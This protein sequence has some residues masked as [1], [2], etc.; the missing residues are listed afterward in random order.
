MF[1]LHRSNTHTKRN[2]TSG[3]VPTNCASPN[4]APIFCTLQQHIP[5]RVPLAIVVQDTHNHPPVGA[6]RSQEVRAMRH[7]R[8]RTH[9]FVNSTTIQE[10]CSVDETTS[11]VAETAKLGIFPTTAPGFRTRQNSTES[12]SLYKISRATPKMADP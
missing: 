7:A 12:T 1:G 8:V 4:R 11:A 6:C 9:Y 5:E 2:R 10:D 3:R